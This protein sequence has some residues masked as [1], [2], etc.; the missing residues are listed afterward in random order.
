VAFTLVKWYFDVVTDD[1]VALVSYAAQLRWGALRLRYASAFRQDAENEVR[2]VST[3]RRVGSPRVEGNRIA[4][5]CPA[6][7]LEGEWETRSPPIEQTLLRTTAGQLRWSCRMPRARATVRLGGDESTGLGYAERLRLT[8]PPNRLP[9]R[10]L[11]WGRHV[12]TVHSVVWIE[13]RGDHER[14]WVWVDGREQPDARLTERGLEGLSGDRELRLELPRDLVDRPVIAAFAHLPPALARR[15]AG[16]VG[17]M[18][19]HKQ[20]ARSKLIEA[21]RPLDSGWT[22]FEEVTW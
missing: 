11:R 15:I 17:T 1:G 12:S 10:L 13:W 2:E 8:I 19:E 18:R 16:P 22:L 3:I 5:R 4:W 14:R 21:G 20:L 6:I 9:F 7:D